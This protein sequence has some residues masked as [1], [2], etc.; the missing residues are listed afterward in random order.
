[1]YVRAACWVASVDS[2]NFDK[3]IRHVTSIAWPPKFPHLPLTFHSSL[4]SS[5]APGNCD[6]FSLLS[7]YLLRISFKGIIDYVTS[8]MSGFWHL[9]SM[10]LQFIHVDM[11]ISN[12]FHLLL[13]S[14]WLVY[15]T[16]YSFT[17]GGE[18]GLFSGKN[19]ASLQQPKSFTYS[20]FSLVFGTV[21]FYIL[22]S[23]RCIVVAHCGFTLH[24]SND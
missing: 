17:R 24:F 8:F 3:H 11:Y 13:S 21:F 1:M 12:Y 20:A 7:F 14:P 19:T 15:P 6:L 23:N 9:I 4:H 18:S 16:I 5:L 10:L 2:M 22:Y